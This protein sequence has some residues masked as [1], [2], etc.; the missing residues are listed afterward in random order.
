KSGDKKAAIKSGDKKAAAKTVAHKQ[1]ILC[2]LTEN[3]SAKSSEISELLGLKPSR[4][5]EL[6]AEMVAEEIIFAEGGNKN[7]T[8]EL[9]T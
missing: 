9:K 1:A 7:R 6:L 4:V 8:Y 2:Y 5:K 3:V